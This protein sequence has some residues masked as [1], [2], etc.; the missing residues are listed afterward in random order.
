MP[1]PSG[2]RAPRR[3]RRSTPIPRTPEAT[4]ARLLAAARSAF[5]QH[6][7]HGA[8]VQAIAD[9]AGCNVSLIS[10]HFGGKLA[11]YRAVL[12]NFARARRDALESH[13]A[14]P[15]RSHDA[16]RD[17]LRVVID[18]LV[19]DH[20][21][22]PDSVLIALRDVN[23]PELWGRELEE[24]LFG[25]ATRLSGLFDSARSAGVLRPDVDPFAAAALVYL[26]FAGM[27]QVAGHVRRV[28]GI[29]L[30]DAATRA[31]VTDQVTR[32]VC[33]GV[34]SPRGS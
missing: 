10:H 34:L 31:W 8:T 5:A 28:R 32:I 6:G 21:R 18:E 19:R 24:L 1:H 13:L 29:T 26:A 12:E 2:R 15:V 20:L 9:A 33:D 14:S 23:D 4:R 27:F 22:D 7:Y 25:F 30:D 11:L 17:R 16:L 3:S